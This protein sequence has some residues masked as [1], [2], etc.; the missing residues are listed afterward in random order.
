MQADLVAALAGAIGFEPERRPFRPHV[1]VGRVPR[2]NRLVVR[3]LD[4]PP[5]LT[6]DPPALTL[7][8]SHTG[9][10]GARYEPLASCSL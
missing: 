3:E 5:A 10:R 7:Y 1:T 9:G 4:P 8:R 6:F 2:G